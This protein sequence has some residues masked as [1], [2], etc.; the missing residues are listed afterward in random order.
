M[1]LESHTLEDQKRYE[2]NLVVDVDDH[3]PISRSSS[4][5]QNSG[6]PR[7]DTHTAWWRLPSPSQ[8]GRGSRRSSEQLEQHNGVVL[9]RKPTLGR[10]TP[11]RNPWELGET[12]Q[13]GGRGEMAKP[14]CENERSSTPP[15]IG[16][17]G[18]RPK[19]WPA[20]M[21]VPPPLPLIISHSPST[22]GQLKS[23]PMN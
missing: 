22:H 9:F 8:S 3:L 23:T 20:T 13:L 5:P 6:H 16:G 18:G 21:V 10:A 1:V 2:M 17:G 12:M 11:A 14:W 19:G 15:F 4:S 7:S